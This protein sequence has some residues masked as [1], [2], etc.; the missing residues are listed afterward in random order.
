MAGQSGSPVIV[1][2]QNTAIGTHVYGLGTKN[3]ASV[4]RG[5]Y[6]NFYNSYQDAI[7]GSIPAPSPGKLYTELKVAARAPESA[8]PPDTEGFLDV[9]KQVVNVGANIGSQVLS[10]GSPFMGPVAGPIGAVAGAALSFAGKLTESS[11]AT[12]SALDADHSYKQHVCRAILSEAALKG[13]LSMGASTRN[14]YGVLE[15]MQKSWEKSKG[16]V[17]IIAQKFGPALMEPALRIAVSDTDKS[18]VGPVQ[19]PKIVPPAGTESALDSGHQDFV[20]ALVSGGGGSNTEGFLDFL[21]SVAK[22]AV[23]VAPS[24]IST[25]GTIVGAVKGESAMAP[26]VDDLQPHFETVCQ[27]A[28]MGDAALQA[29]LQVPPEELKQEG[30]FGTLADTVKSIGSTVVKAMPGVIRVVEPLVHDAIQQKLSGE[31]AMVSPQPIG[32]GKALDSQTLEDFFADSSMRTGLPHMPPLANPPVSNVT[33]RVTPSRMISAARSTD[34]ID[35]SGLPPQE[36]TL[37]FTDADGALASPPT[38]VRSL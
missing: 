22:V 8:F 13:V 20:G 14:K 19:Y 36:D 1:Q 35:W 6:G 28:L 33:S 31:S 34:A 27:R 4:I 15:N 23:N 10:V 2:G 12:E 3:S 17:P 37:P 24:V 32:P 29:I 30:F 9:L 21:G 25:V 18:A 16:N 26:A 11:M 5:Q 7:I 38:P